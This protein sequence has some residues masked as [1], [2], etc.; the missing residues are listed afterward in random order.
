LPIFVFFQWWL[1]EYIG[2]RMFLFAA[3]APLQL[4]ILFSILDQALPLRRSRPQRSR[5]SHH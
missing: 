5:S 1:I 4:L 2:P 3:L